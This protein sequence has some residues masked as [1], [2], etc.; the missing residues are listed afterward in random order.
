VFLT[1]AE[2]IGALASPA[3]TLGLWLGAG[4]LVFAGALTFGELAARR[5]ESG[6]LYVFLREAWGERA[7]FLYGWQC[8]L[9]LD[10]GVTA[11]LASGLARYVVAVFPGAAAHERW[12]ALAAVWILAAA[13]MAGLKP[14]LRSLAL[15]TGWKVLALLAVIVVAFTTGSGSFAHF[16]PFLARR[17]DAPPLGGA[18][19][20]G[21]IGVFFSFG[22][23]WEAS[24]L[25]GEIRVGGRALPRALAAGTAA[26]TLI[27]ALTTAAFLYLVP[28]EST[29]DGAAFA[30]RAGEALFG[31]GGPA[32]LS[33]IVVLSAAASGLALLFMA[34]RVYVAMSRDGLFPAA[35]AAPSASTGAPTLATALLAAV[36]SVYV[37]TGSFEQILALFLCPALAFVALAAAGIF[38]LRR[39]DVGGSGK[40]SGFRCPGY[41]ATPAL[42]IAFLLA[43]A[44]LVA[45]AHPVPVLAGFAIVSLGLAAHRVSSRRQ[46]SR[47]T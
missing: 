24:R 41:P 26:V 34:P 8:V 40:S 16:E 38:R 7:A 10:P 4:A 32:V 28:A 30:R 19:A 23:F 13:P 22:G 5:P 11:G 44:L 35:L 31:R 9:V 45:A 20:A 3:W 47:S 37:L 2:T 29:R 25:A 14:S 46:G 18:L 21:L 39:R 36:A 42:F 33:G 6:G 12:I 17:P 15:L 1:P 43:V 27:Y